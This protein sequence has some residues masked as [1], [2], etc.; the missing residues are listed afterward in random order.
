[1]RHRKAGRKLGRSTSHRRALFRNLATALFHKE[2][3][4]TTLAKAKD[5]RPI[6][7]RLIT[8][9][10]KG[11]L[12]SRRQ[13]LS[14]VMETKIANKVVDELAPRFADRNGGYTRILKLGVRDGD[15][16]EIALIELL[17]SELKIEERKAARKSAKEAKKAK[18]AED[19]AGKESAE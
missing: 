1:M 19:E 5:L 13:I 3:I 2:R 7:E 16:A 17:G 10:K 18:Q 15:K 11:D 6:A 8:L 14:Y 12:H 9:G 4:I